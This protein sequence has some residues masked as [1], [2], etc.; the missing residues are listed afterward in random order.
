MNALNEVW[1]VYRLIFDSFVL[2]N[3]PYSLGAPYKSY[4]FENAPFIDIPPYNSVC[5]KTKK[6]KYCVCAQ[7]K[8]Q[9]VC[10]LDK[11]EF[12]FVSLMNKKGCSKFDP[13]QE[14]QIHYVFWKTR[15]QKITENSL[16]L[17]MSFQHCWIFITVSV[18]FFLHTWNLINV[19]Q[20]VRTEPSEQ[21]YLEAI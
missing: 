14:I 1:L 9:F 19:V 3:V 8:L 2:L 11:Y 18:F 5:P 13:K 21:C 6:K 16:F 10:K 17:S 20:L 4:H 7:S 15:C 12:V